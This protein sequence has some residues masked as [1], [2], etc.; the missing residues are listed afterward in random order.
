MAVDG[1]KLDVLGQKALQAKLNRL[2]PALQRRA[3]RPAVQAGGTLVAKEA[4]KLAPTGTSPAIWRN[5]KN[6]GQARKR[7]KRTIATRMKT[8]SNGTIVC[9]V[10]SRSRE[11]PHGHLVEDGTKPHIIPGPVKLGGRLRI[12]VQHPGS[13][14]R[15][16]LSRSLKNTQAQQRGNFIT[17]LSAGIEKVSKSA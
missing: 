17:K 9:V 4:R 2:K 10:G 6:K 16:W 5:G 7:L 1:I 15:R 12:N 13:K 8:Y 3:I 11:A 14:P